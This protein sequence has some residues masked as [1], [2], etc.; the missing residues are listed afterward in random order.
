MKSLDAMPGGRLCKDDV[1]G[2]N[3]DKNRW[4]NY[5]NKREQRFGKSLILVPE[6]R[7]LA[8]ISGPE[9]SKGILHLV[10]RD[11]F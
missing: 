2:E 10:G 3:W 8:I 11:R 4:S 9:G 5:R 7:L 6:I 1:I